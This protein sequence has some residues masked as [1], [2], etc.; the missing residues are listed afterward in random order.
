MLSLYIQLRLDSQLSIVR[1]ELFTFL[2]K[3]IHDQFYAEVTVCLF[4]QLKA[5]LLI[6]RLILEQ[7]FGLKQYAPMLSGLYEKR[8]ALERSRLSQSYQRGDYH[9]C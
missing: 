1:F 7:G 5:L 4:Q 3:F 9:E 6:P 2:D 8:K